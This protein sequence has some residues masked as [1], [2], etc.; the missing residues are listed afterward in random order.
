MDTPAS[1]QMP[2]VQPV[3]SQ[4]GQNIPVA[5]APPPPPP[6]PKKKSM[7]PMWVLWVIVVAIA[8]ILAAVGI[9]MSVRLSAPD[10]LSIRNQSVVE[11]S[12]RVE[13]TRITS[14]KGGFLV[15]YRLLNQDLY[16]SAVAT[17]FYLFPETYI[18]FTFP[19]NPGIDARTLAGGLFMGVLYEDTDESLHWE[20]E[21]DRVVK[22]LFGKQIKSMFRD[23]NIPEPL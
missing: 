20:P 18:D 9:Y 3:P 12:I 15:I 16:D 21:S 11:G 14:P 23:T 8:A 1:P 2:P 10:E 22:T 5:P 4:Q 13:S 17:S 7:V 19:V 6:A